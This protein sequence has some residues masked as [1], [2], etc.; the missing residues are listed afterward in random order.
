VGC[1]YTFFLG[2]FI[3]FCFVLFCLFVI[4]FFLFFLHNFLIWH[5]DVDRDIHMF[6]LDDVYKIFNG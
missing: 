4:F 5:G 2:S 6:L 1:S 3:L